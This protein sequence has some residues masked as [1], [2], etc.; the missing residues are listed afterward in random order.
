VRPKDADDKR[1]V[2]VLLPRDLATR[3]FEIVGW[4]YADEGKREEWKRNPYGR[5]IYYAVPLEEL[6]DVEDLKYLVDK[7]RWQGE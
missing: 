7:E 1:V 5:G 4:I 6:N 3:R 2:G